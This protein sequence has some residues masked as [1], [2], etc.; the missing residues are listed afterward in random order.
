[1][2]AIQVVITKIFWWFILKVPKMIRKKLFNAEK[3]CGKD[4]VIES[5]VEKDAEKKEHWK[6]LPN[7]PFNR[8]LIRLP[9]DNRSPCDVQL[10]EVFLRVFVNY[11][12]LRYIFWNEREKDAGIK[13]ENLEREFSVY[14]SKDFVFSKNTKGFLDV[15]IYLPSYINISSDI[16]IDV[17][18]YAV[19]DSPFGE[20]VK[21]VVVHTVLTPDKWHE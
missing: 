10:K 8:V 1:M 13:L 16:Y 2:E 9:W 11:A 4:F 3:W 19:F 21:K 14:G 15:Y 18:G 17:V 7:Y 20:F 6:A 12:P 5:R